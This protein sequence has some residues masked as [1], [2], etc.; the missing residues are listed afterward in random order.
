MEIF[1]Y[2]ISAFFTSAFIF[3]AFLLIKNE[4]TFFN[5][6]KII[7]AIH[8]Y[9]I[10]THDYERAMIIFRSVEDYDETLWRLWDFGCKNILPKADYEL[11][12]PYIKKR[13]KTY[14]Y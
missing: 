1:F 13:R 14:E 12:K 3:D 11:I 10:D 7:D 4:I 8:D 2:L 5:Q 9:A 6:K